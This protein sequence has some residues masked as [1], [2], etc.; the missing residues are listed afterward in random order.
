[1]I[2]VM[3]VLMGIDISANSRPEGSSDEIPDVQARSSSPPP[4]SK[5]APPPP[6]EE[7]VMEDESD[8]DVQAK[9]EA[10]DLKAKAGVHYKKRE[11]VEA[12]ELYQKAWDTWPKDITFLSNLAG[13]FPSIIQTSSFSCLPAVYFEQGEYDKSIETCHKAVDEG[14]DVCSPSHL[15]Y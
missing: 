6:V 5:P 14:R 12:A 11:F 2:E 10:L 13:L 8:P 4:P 1:M 7:V 9:K 15:D 3:G